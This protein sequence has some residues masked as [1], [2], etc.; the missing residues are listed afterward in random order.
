[1]TT[2]MSENCR[3]S[4]I[5][6]LPVNEIYVVFSSKVNIR[7]NESKNTISFW[8]NFSIYEYVSNALLDDFSNLIFL[9]CD[10]TVV[11]TGVFNG[12][13]RRLELKFHWIIW[14]IR[15]L[16]FNE[17]VLRRLFERKSSGPSS[18]TGDIGR[19]LKGGEKLPLVAFNSNECEFPGTDPTNLRCDQKYLLDICTVISSG[20]GFSD[21]AKRQQGTLNFARLLTT[22]NR[23]LSLYILTS[24]PSNELITLVVLI[25][26]VYAPSWFQIKVH[27]SIKD[28]ARYLWHFISS[29]PYLPKKYRDIIEPVISRNAYFATPENMLLA[30]LTDYSCC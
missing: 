25:L 30:M 19:N 12:V 2:D 1:M 27:H 14:I 7:N 17:F 13:I 8:V 26:K 3:R 29:S 4:G 20:V 9:V 10:G 6:S 24:T 5:T 16:H 15:L 18:Y 22:A 21:L 23:I 11:N 28:G